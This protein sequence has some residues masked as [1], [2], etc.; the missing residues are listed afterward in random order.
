MSTIDATM[1]MLEVMPEGDRRKVYEFT[2]QLFSARKPAS[3]FTPV[4][5]AQ[6]LSDLE[7]SRQQVT[8]GEGIE[9]EQALEEM[10]Q[11]HGFI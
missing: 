3:P 1:S 5:A 4:S 9:M 10:G 6:V 11:R 2:H 7:E 8:A